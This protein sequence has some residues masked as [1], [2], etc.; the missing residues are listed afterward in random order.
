M[1]FNKTM[2][3][4]LARPLRSKKIGKRRMTS[5]KKRTEVRENST[6]ASMLGKGNQEIAIL[7]AAKAIII[8]IEKRHTTT[9]I[10]VTE[11]VLIIMKWREMTTKKLGVSATINLN[12]KLPA[13]K[14]ELFLTTRITRRILKTHKRKGVET[15]MRD[16]SRKV[17]RQMP[18]QC[19][20]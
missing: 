5:F 15:R 16:G 4:M 3:E 14:T 12:L 6:R 9:I 20:I 13:T 11:I 10:I 17:V 2:T 18:I 1:C 7:D 19:L 8:M